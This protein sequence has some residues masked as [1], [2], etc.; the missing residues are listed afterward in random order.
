MFGP[1][2]RAFPIYIFTLPLHIYC[3]YI[4]MIYSIFTFNLAQDSWRKTASAQE[5]TWK[6]ATLNDHAQ[7]SS[8][9]GRAPLSRQTVV[10]VGHRDRFM[11]SGLPLLHRMHGGVRRSRTGRSVQERAA[12]NPALRA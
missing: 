1:A 6:A 11:R 4:K 2:W 9:D 3:I 8:P 10:G 5:G 12:Q 7:P